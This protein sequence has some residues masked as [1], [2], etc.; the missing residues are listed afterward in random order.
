MDM[1]DLEKD[2]PDELMSSGSWGEQVGGGVK[3]PAQGPGPGGAQLNGDDSAAAALQRQMQINHHLMQQQGNK[4]G[5][6]GHNALGL[7]PLGNK[8][9]NLQSPP[10]V[11][12]SKDTLGGMHPQLMPN[13]SH[14]GQHLTSM[15]MSSLQGAMNVS[16]V[17][18]LIMT[19]SNMGNVMG[20]SAG[21]MGGG[22]LVVNSL[23]KQPVSTS[24]MGPNHHAP[25]HN[26]AQ[27]MQNG[28]IMGRVGGVGPGAQHLV[29]ARPGLQHHPRMSAPGGG[30]HPI[31]PYHPPYAQS[32]TGAPPPRPGARFG[33]PGEAAGGGAAG[34]AV[35][36]AP[37]PQQPQSGAPAGGQPQQAA[38]QQAS[39]P[40]PPTTVAA[41]PPS[42]DNPEKRKLIQ[43]QLVL[44]LH[45]H[46][47]QRRESQSNGE[48]WQCTLPHCK[49]MKGV[50]NHMISCQAGKSC[51]VPHCSSSRQIIN[52]WKH[53]NRNDC[54][55][56]LP[57]KQADRNRTNN[58]NV[59]SNTTPTGPTVRED[60]RRAYDALGIACPTTGPVLG[61]V[62]RPAL[63]ARLPAPAPVSAPPMQ[64]FNLNQQHAPAAPNSQPPVP[65][66]QQQ[67]VLGTGALQLPG[68]QVTATPGSGTKEWHQSITADLRNHLVHKLVQAIFPT[69]DPTAMLDKRMYNLV[70]Y[71]RKVEGDMYEMAG[72]RSEYYHL[73]AEK[74]Y[75][76]QKELEEK[77]QK[78]KEQ[79][80]QQQ[81]QQQQ[82]QPGTV[83]AAV[84]ACVP[85]GPSSL[86]R[87]TLPG[88]P[89]QGLRSH[90]PAM[91]LTMPPGR[92]QFQPGLVGTPGPSPNA[93]PPG[94]NGSMGVGNPGLSPFGQPM[95]SPV[96]VQ[97]GG[98]NSNQFP[99]IG[100]NGPGILGASP[101]QQFPDLIKARMAAQQSSSGGQVASPF[102]S[103]N[104]YA[105][106]M[107]ASQTPTP[108][109]DQVTAASQMSS[110]P[111]SVGSQRGPSPS[112]ASNG[113]LPPGTPS[114]PLAPPAPPSPAPPA[115]QES[116]QQK[117]APVSRPSSSI[118]SQ[119]A[120][121]NAANNPDSPPPSQ[122]DSHSLPGGKLE[123]KSE[124][125]IK[126][127]EAEEDG[128]S[129]AGGKSMHDDV[130][131]EKT[132]AGERAP[133]QEMKEESSVKEEPPS[134]RDVKPPIPEPIQSQAADNKKR[135]CVFKPEEL[136]QALM[137]TLEKL[138]RQD[139]E[140]LPFR[141]PVDP[142]VL[143]I[144]DYF[145]IVTKPMDLSTIKMKL[146]RG[147]YSDPW[148]YVDDV[149]LMFDNAWLYNRKT[150]RVYR[151]CTKLSEVFEQEIDPV[152]QSLGYCCGRKYTFN[153]QVLC[154]YGKQL[155]TIPRDA[156]YFSY[157]NRYTYCQKC[158]N[159][160]AGDTVTLGD[161]PMQPQTAIK[162][163]QFKEMK[164]DHL[165]LEPF[166]ICLD[167]GRKQHQI[168]V[169]HLEHIWPSGFCCENCLKKKGV[170]RK[171]N[172]FN[173]KRL[174]TSKLG[175]YIETRV[176]NYLKKK[177]AMAGEVHI[178][179]VAS[180]DKLVEVKPGMRGRFVDGGE[181][182][183]EFPYRAKAL[184][185][186]EE[187]D[188]ADVCFFG[189]HVQE[190]GSE[191]PTPNTRRVYIAYLDSVHFFKPRQYRTAVYHE[192][193]LGYLDYAKQLGYT[194]AHIWA[195]PPS[196]GDDYIFH[197]H[198]TEQKIPKPRRLQEWYKK[199][200]DKGIIER[201]ILD[202]KDILKQAM[203]D[204]ISSA[205]ELPYFE[206]DFWP[207]VLEESIKELDQEE[208]E[209]RK[210]AEAAEAAIF[211]SSEESEQGADGKKKGQK[212]AKKSNKSKAAQRKNSKKQSDQ[213]TGN[214]LSTK[215]FA[216]MEKHKEVFFVIRLHSAQSAASLAPI[217]DPDS[218]INCDLMDGRDAF[219]TMARDRHYE[220]S[221]MRRARFSTLSML[222]E[223][224]NQGQDKFVYTCNNCKAHVETRYHCTVCDDFDLCIVCFEK[225]GH[226]HKMEKLGLDLDDGSA[227]GDTKQANP[228]EAR[229]LSI[230]RC[231]QS[232]VHAC[233]CRDAN[234][235][236]PSC[237]KMKRVVTHTKICKRK[238]N[239][240]CPICKQLIALCCYHAKHCQETKCLVP[241]CSNI[242]HK[243]KQQQL[244][245]RLQQAQLLRRRMAVM[246]TR[247]AGCAAGGA[248]A[249][250]PPAAP[251][252]AS[253]PAA[254]PP[255]PANV[256][257]VVKQVQEE[258][259]RQQAPHYGKAAAMA[260]PG[261]ARAPDWPAR[262]PTAQLRQP[263]PLPALH[264]PAAPH[265]M[266]HHPQ[267]QQMM[268]QQNQQQQLMGMVG[269]QQQTV[270]GGGG[271]AR[272][273][274]P[275]SVMQQKAL[276]QLM[277]TLRS[278]TSPDQQA[279]IL[280]ILK[281]NPPLM[282]AFIKQRQ[283]VQN[284]QA[285]GGVGG[286]ASGQGA[287]LPH[288]MGPSAPQPQPQRL[289]QMQQM[290]G[291][292]Q[293]QV[294][295]VGGVNNM[296]QMNQMGGMG[297]QHGSWSF[298]QQLMTMRSGG[299][300]GGAAGGAAAAG[301]FPAPAY[302]APRVAGG[303]A[304]AAQRYFSPLLQRSPPA[305]TS[306]RPPAPAEQ[307]LLL[308]PAGA[309]P[310][311]A[312]DDQL[313]PMTPQDQLTKFVEQL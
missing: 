278:P 241:F 102:M 153:P 275:T 205:A 303:V 264:H 101:S 117:S 187:V 17:G 51:T 81:Q 158:F 15:P 230:Q 38:T 130:K 67:Q 214:D 141:Q 281:S 262:Y 54:P 243:L 82:Q 6:G 235:R 131:Q 299:V 44:L 24:L 177:E 58:L 96:S 63:T 61:A 206:G 279:Q 95:T 57:L 216:T 274:A 108:G 231:I 236:L 296:G 198:P 212:K 100:T 196:E 174:P 105:N 179:V 306:P 310:P 39:A 140:S 28:P 126:K 132:E 27:G 199:M 147:D 9:P 127:E 26:P 62:A 261:G 152:M 30:G 239:G 291:Q 221:S 237:Q 217:Q 248:G 228:Q 3:P 71:A 164:N 88:Q 224:H 110:G 208:E 295:G 142:Q 253:P 77:R 32:A 304:G 219:L 56:C 172:K 183:G 25:H 72:T 33:P 107:S 193:L 267:Q 143:C 232:L 270:V 139:P 269:Q 180:S 157:Q 294:G 84:R 23:N 250:P 115:S 68:G 165:E 7:G 50:L 94:S 289:Q 114:T 76:I 52:H 146:D 286:A 55:V 106:R 145:D 277:T 151:Y 85:G 204:N 37:S 134:P 150:S 218:L 240:G 298:K 287:P 113:P 260:P 64:L 223:L 154:C 97:G 87:Q 254:K 159:D 255:P 112:L 104:Q 119:M 93:L 20:G 271:A 46:K 233:Q 202:Y 297:Q 16:N 137:P 215:I 265:H 42:I 280:H 189:M 5:L 12:V 69:P 197:C 192:I 10:N 175:V 49:T 92:V 103:Q 99:P 313:P 66:L 41:P 211:Q 2:L 83:G 98:T 210:Q 22:G 163:D 203:E 194:M 178:R 292:Q 307:L 305:N 266:H 161:D 234:C 123:I 244:Q 252:L 182:P 242:K 8:S 1:F 226:P 11:S 90:S 268:P 184:F 40:A 138:F 129:G 70:A 19:N 200:L 80:M 122:G 144:P 120:A 14:P 35:P 168:C 283:N 282:A 116:V 13:T 133:D 272:G 222:W 225:D 220:F 59:A 229:K 251:A 60:M 308:R 118:S 227:P 209:K 53:C 245:Q 246:N 301:G 247:G 186:F 29:G 263:P 160:I 195:C 18:G 45:A 48:V 293:Q 238:T 273:A 285:G 288:M 21:V 169:L 173:A 257:Q 65:D 74:I 78:R 91:G 43:Q 207:N 79:Q 109:A 75:K 162:K 124:D 302:G 128:H 249:S 190:Y 276:Q 135:K 284:Q 311:P 4:G 312:L 36:P 201:I 148:E 166:V 125:D 188:G 86:P 167:C 176:N 213:Q 170:K 34:Q 31:A 111:T 89:P 136:R 73:L 300:A 47:C 290:M 121:L 156:K 149:W 181:L 256:L 155:C 191:C 258:A 185:A 309:A 171:E 259:A